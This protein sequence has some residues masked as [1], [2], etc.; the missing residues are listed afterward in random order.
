MFHFLSRFTLAARIYTGFLFLGI[1]VVSICFASVFAVGYVH[2][3]YTKANNIIES[4]RQLSALENSLFDLNRSLYFFAL[5][6]TEDEKKGVEEAFSSF[7][8]KAKE[9]EG[10]LE[11]PDVREKYKLVL[12]ASLEKYRADMA[13]MFSLHEKSAEAAEKVNQLAEK[14]SGQLNALIEETTLPSAS[15]ALN[16]LR[17][18]LDVVLQFIDSAPA[19]NAE[20]Q[21]QLNA[22]FASLKKAQNTAKQ[23]EMINTKQ[24]K[25]LFSTFSS[26]EE[27]ITRK[28]KIDQALHEKMKIV[29]SVGDQNSKDLKDLLT[30]MGQSCAQLMAQA[31]AGKISLQKIFVF[32][33]AMG[34]VFAVLLSFLSLFGIRY[35]LTRLIENAQEMARG[36]HSV[37]IHFTERDDEVGA[38]AKALA[39]LLVRLKEMPFLS[40]E[41]LRSRQ[42]NTYGSSIAYTPVKTETESQSGAALEQEGGNDEFAYF[43]QGVGVD[44][45]SQLCQMLFLVQ[46]ISA[47]AAEMTQNIK[48]R[49]SVCR[50]HLQTLRDQ[51]K[52]I[53]ENTL[54]TAE[55]M[56]AM[57][58]TELLMQINNLIESFSACFYQTGETNEL[59]MKQC[60][61][62]EAL[63]LQ[64][65]QVQR[66]VPK[67]TEWGRIAGELTGI[68]H[69]LSSETKILSLNASIEAAKSGENAKSFGAVA[70]DMR[71]RTHK[72]AETAEQLKMHLTSIRDDVVHFAE[73]MGT[74]GAR[75]EE[76]R[77]SIQQLRPI[78]EGQKN[79]VHISFELAESVKKTAENY[80]ERDEEIHTRLIAL[81]AD[82][83][84]T[85]QVGTLFV[86]QVAEAEQLLDEFN[87]SLPTYEEDKEST[88]A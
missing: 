59:L 10:Y 25:M 54:L 70:L 13:E 45:E 79:Q 69:S 31:E 84:Q 78:Q 39:V 66:F 7:E 63:V 15:F 27:E 46:H 16:G 21:K 85:G 41:M 42:N 19:E 77:R 38:L 55:K 86:Q 5:K 49:F 8:E 29:S 14:A 20:T 61:S 33:A 68:I 22:D 43:G 57:S 32:A 26:L 3:E 1:Y 44:T 83:D 18:Q 71:H 37:L 36:E 28:L 47:A 12:G 58:T 88:G 82:I 6:E 24:L 30:V 75:I 65:E 23:A 64:L 50:D 9:V 11:I 73:A 40:G 67:L 53:E 17:E 34:G 35:P 60:D 4:T 2:R 74:V 52:N 76:L 80:V 56:E 87:L 48:L 62:L 81:P 51:M 72:T